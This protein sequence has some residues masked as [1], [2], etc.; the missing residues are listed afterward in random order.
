MIDSDQRQALDKSII[1]KGVN[2][3]VIKLVGH[4]YFCL[5]IIVPTKDSKVL[6]PNIGVNT[7]KNKQHIRQCTT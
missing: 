4:Y 1:L 6:K 2:M 5:F 7:T 3:S